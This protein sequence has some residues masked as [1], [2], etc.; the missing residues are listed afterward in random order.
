MEIK[1]KPFDENRDRYEEWFDRHPEVYRWELDAVEELLPGSGKSIEIGVGS[2]RFSE[3]FSIEYG[4]DPSDKM[5]MIAK[6]RGIQVVKGIGE[7]LPIKG[8]VFD[9]VLIVTTICFFE[10]VEMALK[11]AN[12][13]L[14]QGGN[15]VIGFIDKESPLGIEYR[16]KK[17][18]NVFYR[19][20]QFFSVEQVEN[21]LNNA[22]FSEF[23]YVQTVFHGLNSVDGV[24]GVKMRYGEGSFV[25]IK[26]RKE[27]G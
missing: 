23:E 21:L 13:V 25:V 3:P 11:E 27:R 19:E 9:T 14:K 8:G 6:G 12:R 24:E 18:Q 17:G 2:G 26:G 22:G 10:D 16:R 15:I 1:V 4:V 20:A 5:L 7:E